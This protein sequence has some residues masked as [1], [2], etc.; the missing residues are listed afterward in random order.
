VILM[1]LLEKPEKKTKAKNA[2]RSAPWA[3]TFMVLI[4]GAL[5]L[6]GGSSTDDGLR[7]M[8]RDERV[9]IEAMLDVLS[10]NEKLH[11]VMEKLKKRLETST[12]WVSKWE[13]ELVHLQEN[14]IIFSESF[15]DLDTFGQQSA[16][17][18][19]VGQPISSLTH[20]DDEL[21]AL[22]E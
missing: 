18:P 5:F 7:P 17:L 2:G 16:L 15:F 8:A 4:L 11:P 13:K 22:E 1:N 10:R 9:G 20:A 19:L 21:A 3:L 12:W 6:S 14:Q